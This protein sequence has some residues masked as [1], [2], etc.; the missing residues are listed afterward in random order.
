MTGVPVTDTAYTYVNSAAV[1]IALAATPVQ[2]VNGS[3]VPATA[4]VRAL[5]TLTGGL[6]VQ[7]AWAP[8]DAGNGAFA[9]ALGAGAPVRTAYVPNPAA[10]AFVP[11]TGA[12]AHYTIEAAAAGAIKTQPVDVT[13][14][15]P[16]LAFTFP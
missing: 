12:A 1:P 15:V 10:L 9:F 5:Q 16:P 8:V 7:V 3:V 11:D 13:S 14:A 2:A 6:T 4:T